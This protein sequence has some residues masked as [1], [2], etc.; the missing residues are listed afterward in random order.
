MNCNSIKTLLN[1]YIDNELSAEENEMVKQHLQE[2]MDCAE[3]TVE[4]NKVKEMVRTLSAINAPPQLSSAV[5]QQIAE[6]PAFKVNIFWSYQW[7]L[8]SL[9]SAAAAFI[10]IY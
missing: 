1:P 3:E 9:A 8:G 10:I 2:C 6:S 4:L 5:S 7:L